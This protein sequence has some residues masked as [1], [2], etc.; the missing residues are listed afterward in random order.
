MIVL[1]AGLLLLLSLI[2]SGGSYDRRGRPRQPNIVTI[3]V[4]DLGW[5]DLNS[6]T[7][8]EGQIPT[9]KLDKLAASSRRARPVSRATWP[10]CRS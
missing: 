1:H 4:D 9:P 8:G 5:G 3:V 7:G 10:P 2:S 6:F